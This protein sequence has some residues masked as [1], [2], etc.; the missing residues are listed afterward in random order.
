M[1]CLV[2][3]IGFLTSCE[4]NDEES[5]QVQLLSFGPSGVEHGEKISFIGTNLDQV[6]IIELPGATVLKS[7]F[8]EQTSDV[9]VLIVPM[10]TQEG[11]VTLKTSSGSIVSKTILSFDVPVTIETITA[12]AK[13]GSTITITGNFM[14]WVKEVWFTEE[15]MV[16]EFVS[17]SLTELV[18]TVPM[19]A[20]TGSISLVT[21]GTEPLL[22]ETI[23]ELIVTLPSV[24]SLNSN[25]IKHTDNLTILGSDLD[26]ITSIVFAGNQ[27]VTEFISQSETEIVVAIPVGTI[28]GKLTLKQAS[29]VD[30]VTNDELT[31]ILPVGTDLT[32]KPAT[33]G[34][35]NIT[36]TGTN[37]DL[38]ASLKLPSVTNP[39]LASSFISHTA[40]QIVLALPAAAT[41]GGVSYTTIHG[42]SNN[43]GV[44]ISLPGAGPSPLPISLYNETFAPGG[45]DWSWN[46]TSNSSS[47]E[48]FYLGAVSWKFIST[49]NGGLSSGGITPIDVSSMTYFSF[50]VYGGPGTNGKQIACILNDK[51]DSYNSVTL[52]EGQWKEYKVALT[53]YATV[54]KTAIVRFA[55]KVEGMATST[56]YADRM[57]F[58]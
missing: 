42:Y 29:P 6:D 43:L 47:T 3:V 54:D 51:F 18:V 8:V 10:Q 17:Q 52:V 26:L 2:M 23:D 37:L 28:K 40:T 46:G 44:T 58:E 48:Q 35:S 7:D 36:I 9:I 16:T 13:P 34:T 53:N 21:G 1:I 45:G 49:D 15:L 55:L 11:F 57:G 33:P 22:I 14:N 31:I 39:I 41:A 12:E 24:T 4:N 19:E 56:I 25:P 50:S 38:V 5:G 32:P 27:T 20:Q 30:V